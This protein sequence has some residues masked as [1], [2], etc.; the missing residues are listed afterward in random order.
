MP[1][2]SPPVIVFAPTPGRALSPDEIAAIIGRIS[3]SDEQWNALYQIL[4]R[5]LYSASID[6][7][8][9]SMTEREAGHAGG[10]IHE[11]S[12]FMG[13]LA[14]YLDAGVKKKS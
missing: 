1:A 5:R 4:Q 9:P 6:A 7:A 8:Q 11:I 10:R 13:E 2:K 3:R 12:A 14:S